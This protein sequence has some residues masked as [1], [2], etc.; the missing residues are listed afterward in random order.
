MKDSLRQMGLVAGREFRQL[1][2]T[3]L[4]WV[5]SGV[6]FL[7]TALVYVALIVGF[8]YNFAGEPSALTNG[9]TDV[10][11]AVI[12][13]LFY[14]VH[15]FLMIQIPL[16]TMR[17]MAE[18]NKSNTLALLKTMPVGEWSIIFGKF[19]ANT[20]AIALY[21]L[22]TL[23]FPLVT[24]LI[25]DP[26]WPV[27]IACY[28]ALLLAAAAYVATGIFFSSITESQVI[29]AVL[30]Y[31]F[32]FFLLVFTAVADN[33]S[34]PVISQLAAHLTVQAHIEG[35]LIGNVALPDVVYFTV[36]AWMFIFAAVRI[37]ES[38]RWRA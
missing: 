35:F 34:A 3:P 17:S 11:I 26:H 24:E 18:E 38:M 16:L 36:F 37:L 6:F 20:G 31:V 25:S 2:T 14:I 5:L 22:I 15:Y 9:S 10:T 1:L 21:L 13:D 30:T 27:I 8:S 19:L 12:H 4:F 7:A 29:A 23:I 28:L 33:I 32:L